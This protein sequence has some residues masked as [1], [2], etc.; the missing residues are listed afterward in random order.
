VTLPFCIKCCENQLGVRVKLSSLIGVVGLGVFAT[1]D[2]KRKHFNS[3]SSI[4]FRTYGVLGS[5]PLKKEDVELLRKLTPVCP[6]AKKKFE[7]LV[8]TKG[9]LCIDGFN[10]K[11]SF[12]RFVNMAPSGEMANC[13]VN[14]DGLFELCCDVKQG[15]ELLRMYNKELV[16][17]NEL[18]VLSST[19]LS[20]LTQQRQILNWAIELHENS[21][22]TSSSSSS[23]KHQQNQ[24]QQ[25][26]QHRRSI[27]SLV[28][29][30]LEMIDDSESDGDNDDRWISL[31]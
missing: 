2:L 9:G 11:A 26:Q 28:Q 19:T 20:E 23:S 31:F 1:R 16:V 21:T 8:E 12:W 13:F 24:Q 17:A 27:Q 22:L 29:S 4:S 14:D 10:P 3:D 6:V 5:P 25:Q 18:G 15:E 30:Q 7:Y